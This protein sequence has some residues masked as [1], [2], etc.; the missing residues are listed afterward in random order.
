MTHCEETTDCVPAWAEGEQLRAGEGFL[1][2]HPTPGFTHTLG[3]LTVQWPC[4][5]YNKCTKLFS[6]IISLRVDR[7]D[8]SSYLY[9][10][11]LLNKYWE[12]SLSVF[13]L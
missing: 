10:S 6:I 11:I 13:W 7:G 12:F 5:V 2:T 3:T 1:F 8:R 4:T 9:Y